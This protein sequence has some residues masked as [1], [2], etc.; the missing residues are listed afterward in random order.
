MLHQQIDA[1]DCFVDLVLKLFSVNRELQQII[2]CVAHLS[3]SPT[4]QRLI[5]QIAHYAFPDVERIVRNVVEKVVTWKSKQ[6]R[7]G[8]RVNVNLKLVTRE[9][10]ATALSSS[11]L[12]EQ[13]KLST[14]LWMKFVDICDYIISLVRENQI[15]DDMFYLCRAVDS[16]APLTNRIAELLAR[17]QAKGFENLLQT[18]ASVIKGAFRFRNEKHQ[19]R[20]A[21]SLLGRFPHS[22][23]LIKS[24]NDAIFEAAPNLKE[25]AQ[26][27]RRELVVQLSFGEMQL[28]TDT[29]HYA[30]SVLRSGRLHPGVQRNLS[31][32]LAAAPQVVT[33]ESVDPLRVAKWLSPVC[34]CKA[35]CP[36][37]TISLACEACRRPLAD[38]PLI[39]PFQYEGFGP[40]SDLLPDPQPILEPRGEER[41]YRDVFSARPHLNFVAHVDGAV[42]AIVSA[43]PPPNG[44]THPCTE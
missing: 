38:P 12:E 40:V 24:V 7:K 28:I 1:S 33:C 17:S 6:S 36:W 10:E 44:S 8:D 29:L 5:G 20:E 23:K 4:S 16:I 22:S 9:S 11:E 37:E 30:K 43:F 25:E 35:L 34:S 3:S 32:A 26:S 18:L 27:P 31:D 21:A 15:P 13:N 14:L 41:W 19:S 42:V 2:R 39:Q